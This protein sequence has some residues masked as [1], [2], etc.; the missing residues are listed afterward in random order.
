MEW[1]LFVGQNQQLWAT[2]VP[3]KKTSQGKDDLWSID[4]EMDIKT[5][6]ERKYLDLTNAK[7]TAEKYVREWFRLTLLPLLPDAELVEE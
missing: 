2:L 3:T 6:P 5:G 1:F 7:L 4:W